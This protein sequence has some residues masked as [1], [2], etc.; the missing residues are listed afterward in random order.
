[1]S[2]PFEM[3]EVVIEEDHEEED[4]DMDEE[5]IEQIPSAQECKE[6][7]TAQFSLNLFA[8]IVDRMDKHRTK[9]GCSPHSQ[10]TK[11]RV[12]GVIRRG[13]LTYT[14]NGRKDR[15][16]D[17]DITML[18]NV[19]NKYAHNFNIILAYETARLHLTKTKEDILESAI[20][21]A[22]K[23]KSVEENIPMTQLLDCLQKHYNEISPRHRVML[24]SKV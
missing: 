12:L 20:M 16:Y 15:K 5:L 13:I 4:M 8:E 14:R 18:V 22:N 19:D 23:L 9:Y 7:P 21:I 24:F 11:S 10:I 3:D 17:A 6:D 1:M 2:Q